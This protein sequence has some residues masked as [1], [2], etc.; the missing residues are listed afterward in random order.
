MRN[1]RLFLGIVAIYAALSIIFVGGIGGSGDLASVKSALSDATNGH[2]DQVSVGLTLFTFLIGSAGTAAGQAAGAY[3]VVLLLLISLVLI[4]ALRHVY[5]KE[6][7]THIRD[8]F[9]EA[10]QPLVPFVLVLCV[11]G[12]ELLPLILGVIAYDFL[13][14]Y[15][16]LVDG[17]EHV[18]CVLAVLLLAV[19]SLYMVC[20]SI[21]ALYVVTLPDMTPVKALRSARELV[22]YRRFAVLRKLLFLP[23]V[24]V[25]VLAVI[26]IPIALF[27]TPVATVALFVVT[28]LGVP[29]I[30]SYGYEL[31]R[32][33]LL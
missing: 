3:Q 17:L 29:V 16:I 2:L 24:L 28:M 12:L 4:W 26:L 14:S 6:T 7:N 23:I 21:F 18:V 27:A 33:L 11:V 20:S 19:L 9:Y 8:A 25:V 32:E 31:Y 30:I 1:W 22:R 5:I 10:P 13:V 15:G